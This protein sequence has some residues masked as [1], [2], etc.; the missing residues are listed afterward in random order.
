MVKAALWALRQLSNSDTVK[1]MLAE[2]NCIE[3][4]RGRGRKGEEGW[5][6]RGRGRGV[7]L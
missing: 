3:E 5:V 2:N 4:V 1:K 6:A 7:G